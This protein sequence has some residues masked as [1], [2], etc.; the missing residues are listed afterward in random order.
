MPTQ[1]L[2]LVRLDI[3]HDRRDTVNRLYDTVHIP[4]LLK[5][6]GVLKASRYQTSNVAEP[7]YLAIYEIANPGVTETPQWKKAADAGGWPTEGR[8][9]IFNAHRARYTWVG[10]NTELTYRTRFLFFATM[11][12][13]PHKE[14]LFN[15]LYDTEHIPLITKVPGC[16]NA[17]RYKTSD[18]GHPKYLAIYEIERADLPTSDG[19]WKAADTGRWKPEVRPYTYNKHWVVY[20]RMGEVKEP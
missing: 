7:R 13:E 15:E 4:A 12:V 14:A 20:E 9:Y 17:V 18:E 10:G 19:W 3:A 11:D 2:F 6:P 8:P 1:Y 16:L 5:V